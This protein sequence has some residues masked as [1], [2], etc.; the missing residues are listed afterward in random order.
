M[1]ILFEIAKLMTLDLQNF[2][3]QPV[4]KMV[5]KNTTTYTTRMDVH[6]Q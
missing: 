2:N 5:N 1:K 3:D 6:K 4:S